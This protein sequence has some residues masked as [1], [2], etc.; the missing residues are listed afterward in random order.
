[1]K[2]L[3]KRVNNLETDVKELKTRYK[4]MNIKQKALI[5]AI[6][7]HDSINEI[8]SAINRVY[9]DEIKDTTKNNDKV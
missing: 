3:E 9:I 5:G 2:T 6:M 7:R 8:Q 4:T 1:M